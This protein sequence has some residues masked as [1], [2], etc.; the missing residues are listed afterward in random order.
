MTFMA[1][2]LGQGTQWP[3]INFHIRTGKAEDTF[4]MTL[5]GCI[6]GP[7]TTRGSDILAYLKLIKPSWPNPYFAANTLPIADVLTRKELGWECTP[8]AASS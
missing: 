3:V 4:Q 2:N 6:N 8:V 7:W 5:R 1:G